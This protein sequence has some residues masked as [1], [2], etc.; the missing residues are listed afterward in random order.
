MLKNFW[1]TEKK[2]EVNKK[3]GDKQLISPSSNLEYS[4]S[5]R[6]LFQSLAAQSPFFD[7]LFFG[8]FK[9]KDMKEIP[10]EGVGYEVCVKQEEYL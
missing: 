4:K 8:N 2:I 9:E 7:R 6:F 3:V 1:K 10:I 5:D